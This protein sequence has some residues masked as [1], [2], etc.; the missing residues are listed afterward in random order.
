[1]EANSRKFICAAGLAVIAA[2]AAWAQV[3]PPDPSWGADRL[4]AHVT[5]GDTAV[6][7]EAAKA[8]GELKGDAVAFRALAGAVENGKLAAPVRLA[9]I[10]VLEGYGEPRAAASYVAVLGDDDVRWAAADALLTFKSDDVTRQ[11]VRT[12]SSDKKA[13]RRATAAY[14]LGRFRDDAA[15]EPLLAALGDRDAD[16]RVRACAAAACYGNARAVEPLIANLKRDKD[17]RGRRAAA[18]ALGA[19]TDERSV[20]PLAE[21][22]S[23]KNADVRA[24]AAASLAAVGD[25]RALDPL[26]AR[27]KKEKDAAARAAISKALDDLKASILS[28][29]KP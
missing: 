27:L 11:L 2:A 20:K 21:A 9:A 6:A 14:A 12:L 13:K 15:F 25:A 3:G 29:V 10:R 5:S 28:E 18:Q 17:A 19:V 24:A 1:M 16:V 26:R 4:A 23:D 22:L 7:V 8:L